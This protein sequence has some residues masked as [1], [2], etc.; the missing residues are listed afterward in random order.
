MTPLFLLKIT[1][2]TV[3]N[4]VVV[5]LLC[6]LVVVRLAELGLLPRLLPALV[7]VAYGIFLP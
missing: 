3:L 7:Q 1:R 5:S 2:D 4:Q 6:A